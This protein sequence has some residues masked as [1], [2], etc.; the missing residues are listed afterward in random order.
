M[1]R[2]SIAIIHNQDRQRLAH[3]QPASRALADRVGATLFEVYEQPAVRPH[4]FLFMFYRQAIRWRIGRQWERHRGIAP[5][6]LIKSAIYHTIRALGRMDIRLRRSSAIEMEL[7]SKHV[8]A[9]KS[10][11]EGGGDYLAVLEDDAVMLS[12][13]ADRFCILLDMLADRDTSRLLYVDL[14]GGF[15]IDTLGISALI[16]GKRDGF[17]HFKRPVTNTA[18]GYLISRET[19]R[20]FCDILSSHPR[21]QYLAIDWMIN[22]LMLQAFSEGPQFD[23]WHSNPPLF[24]HGSVTGSYRSWT[25]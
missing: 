4:S 21:F 10:F 12:N 23:C 25:I 2:I 8:R 5:T 19:A 17:I 16:D 7:A 24:R 13:T 9:W 15:S 20:R 18:C 11:I 3:I 14:A 6:P 22:G 1:S